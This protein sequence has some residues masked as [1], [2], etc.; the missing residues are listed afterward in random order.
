MIDVVAL[1]K[2]LVKWGVSI[3]KA[4]LVPEVVYKAFKVAL[5]EKPGAVHI[6]LPED[7]ASFEAG[8]LKPIKHLDKVRRS[9][10]DDKAIDQIWDMLKDAKKPVI[11]AGNGV[12]RHHATGQL[13]EFVDATKIPVVNTFMAKG[14][15]ARS[16][17]AALFTVGLSSGDFNNQVLEGSDLV[18]AIGYDV[19][20][21]H[22]KLWNPDSDLRI[23]HIDFAPAEVD[24]HYR[25]A[26]EAV[27]DLSHSLWML[28]ERVKEEPIEVD[29]SY[30]A[31]IRQTMLD[32]FAFH[33][34]DDQQG[35][36]KPQKMLW[37]L[38]ETLG[39][40]DIAISD[41]GAHKMWFS[42]YY[43]A[44]EPLTAIVHN[45]FCSMGGALP[46]AIAAKLAF[47]DRTVV[48]LAG[49]GAFL[50]N[51]QE[52]E[53]ARRIGTNIIV[54]VWV[55]GGYGLI[56]WKQDNRWNKHSDLSF[57]NPDFDALAQAFDWA[58]FACDDSTKLAGVLQDAVA[59]TAERPVLVS[60]PIDYAEN[61]KLTERLGSLRCR[62]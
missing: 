30:Y 39:P 14:A 58:H 10:P 28:N 42:R 31:D 38:R 47:P 61:P 43:Q 44:D 34:A 20:E 29:P 15:I 19:V 6:E 17:P 60:I 49:D 11:L 37:D 52:M 57:G 54:V 45:G 5:T 4:S 53:T 12:L 59:A 41:V 40:K 48:A 62:E 2:P 13:T 22:P 35:S 23:A 36:I 46:G 25:T 8:D 26:A 55:D 7:V 9:V 33:A 56:S 18:L 16:H 3:F 51:V 21:Y 50:Q 24:T 27:G 1:F 32:D